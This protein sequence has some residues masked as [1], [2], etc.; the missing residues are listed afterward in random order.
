[1]VDEHGTVDLD[2]PD[3]RVG[4]TKEETETFW[5][6]YEAF[7]E[8]Q[9]C[10]CPHPDMRYADVYVSN[11]GGYRLFQQA[12]GQ[13]GWEHFPTLQAQL[14][15]RDSGSSPASAAAAALEELRYFIEVADLGSNIFL[16]DSDTGDVLHE[17]MAAYQGVFL[18]QVRHTPGLEAGVDHRGFFIREREGLRREHF[19]SQRFLQNVIS[20]D[21]P[22]RSAEYVDLE[23]GRQYRCAVI[24]CSR[25]VPWPDGRLQDDAGRFCTH[26]SAR[27]HTEWRPVTADYYAYVTEPLVEVFKASLATGNPVVWC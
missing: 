1:M 8:W 15:N 16:I 4:A 20:E 26:Y 12:L 21:G 2:L 17:Y 13:A 7:E 18:F 14:P 5:A 25:H 10:A 11:W 9:K 6:R 19:R 27:L 23:S 24:A 22:E 3:P